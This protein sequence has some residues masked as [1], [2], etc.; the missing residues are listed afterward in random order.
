MQTRPRVALFCETFHEINGVAL[1]A[2]QLAAFAS[3]HD[4]PLLAVHGGSQRRRIQE[5]SVTRLELTRSWSSIPIESDLK[6]DFYF[7]R[8]LSQ[9]RGELLAFRPDVIHITSPGELGQLGVYL[10]R[11][12]RIPLVASWHTNFHQFVA[13][14]FQKLIGFLPQRYSQPPVAWSQEQGLRILLWFYGFADV[15]LAPTQ[16]QVDWL[17]EKLQKPSFLMPRGVDAEQFDPRHRTL[18]DGTLRLGFVGRVTPEKSVRLLARV[19]KA[20]EAAGLEN[21]RVLIVG[22]GSEI[23]WL[24]SHLRRADFAGVLR[25][26]PLAQAYAN[27][28]IFVFPSRTDTFGNVIQEAA[29]SGVPSVVTDEGGPKNLVNPGVTG[30]VA[31]SDEEFVARVV[32]LALDSGRRQRMGAGAREKV[33]NCSWDAAFEMTYRAYAHCLTEPAVELPHQKKVLT[34]DQRVPLAS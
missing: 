15:T 32:E 18:H 12:L 31:H 1:T 7:W 2:R 22:D 9:I 29:A 30:V 33:A 11:K 19:E 16:A 17:S 6:Y 4:F 14:R 24:K 23:G 21:F 10:S 13:R 8:Y 26:H 5:G 34:P 28:D 25:G 3:R 20:L 27:M